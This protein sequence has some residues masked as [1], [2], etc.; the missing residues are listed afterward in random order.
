LELQVE[1][2]GVEGACLLSVVVVVVVVE[3]AIVR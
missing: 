3:A 2:E 1:V